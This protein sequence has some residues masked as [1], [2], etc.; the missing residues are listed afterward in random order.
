MAA[1]K[2]TI[3]I[4][5]GER[6]LRAVE[7]RVAQNG[8]T[9]E[10]ALARPYPESL[11]PTNAADLGRWIG[12]AIGSAGFGRGEVVAT[13]DREQATIR[14]VELPSVD[15]GELPDMARLLMQRETPSEA[16]P[17]VVDV[18]P[19]ERT[20]SGT[21]VIVAAAPER[22][23]ES[24]RQALAQAGLAAS[25]ISL[26]TFGVARLLAER[27]AA[28]GGASVLGLD[29]T[30][31]SVELISVSGGELRSS[32]CARFA[33]GSEEGRDLL[34]SEVKRVVMAHRLAHPE[35]SIAEIVVFARAEDR[36]TLEGIDRAL[37]AIPVGF[38]PPPGI[39][40]RPTVDRAALDVAWPLVG[41]LLEAR[42]DEEILNLA[43]PRKAP[44]LALRRRQRLLAVM[45]TVVVAALLGWTLGSQS[46]RGFE[47][48]VEDLRDK[49]TSALPEH[50][51]FKRDRFR[52]QHLETWESARPI[53]LEHLA[54]L[55]EF[56]GEP[57]QVLFDSVTATLEA[58]DV[59]YGRDRLW[60]V[61]A[62]VKIAVD[63]EAKDRA[64]A[65]GL[66]DALVDDARFSLT[67][68]GADGPGGRR[69]GSPFSY[70]LRA[71]DSR[72]PAARTAPPKANGDAQRRERGS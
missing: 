26:R 27:P 58:S 57:G 47:A 69:L 59:R 49:A 3:A 10:R 13:L 15:S 62:E 24:L 35:D 33:R 64:V 54:F 40:A 29:C 63:G 68:T 12:E 55:R 52:L 41:L 43:A 9:V 18:L 39:T 4:D 31:E 25:E 67:S 22:S 11:D 70:V 28:A 44:D 2:R 23:V 48:T 71:S 36:A 42:A 16:G 46:R 37:G 21:T 50:L 7:V 32:S 6:F 51:R 5:P 66:R 38:D 34:A 19:R 30:G 72:S 45:G 8:L 53:W 65:D 60:S 14:R 61:E 56:T 17:L 20:A 1:P